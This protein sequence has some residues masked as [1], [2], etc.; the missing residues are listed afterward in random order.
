MLK[1]EWWVCK[2]SNEISFHRCTISTH[3]YSSSWLSHRKSILH[4]NYQL[5]DWINLACDLIIHFCHNIQEGRFAGH[6]S[7]ASGGFFLYFGYGFDVYAKTNNG[8]YC[9]SFV[10]FLHF[11]VQV[12]SLP[13][14]W[15]KQ[16]MRIILIL[17]RFNFTSLVQ[18]S[19]LFQCSRLLTIICQNS[20][21]REMEIYKQSLIGI[22]L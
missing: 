16:L 4:L 21:Y 8:E 20:G 12:S 14:D 22:M 7:V 2:F 3:G 17:L 18:D 10:R 9:A 5:C 1:W 11:M 6:R 15:E 13:L 19:F